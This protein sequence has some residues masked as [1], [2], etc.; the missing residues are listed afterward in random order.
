MDS[1][2][3]ANYIIESAN[4]SESKYLF[5]ELPEILSLLSIDIPEELKD[6]I[7]ICT[8]SELESVLGKAELNLYIV[9]N[10]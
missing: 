1:G 9:K 3:L 10:K 4:S 2:L 8:E 5:V 6:N 7:L